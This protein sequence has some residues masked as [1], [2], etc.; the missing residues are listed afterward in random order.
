[1]DRRAL[2]YT[3][4]HY[5]KH[6]NQVLLMLCRAMYTCRNAISRSPAAPLPCLQY[7]STAEALQARAQ[8]PGAP[9]KKFH[10]TIKRQLI[11]RY[12]AGAT[13]AS[14]QQV[15]RIE[16]P[17]SCSALCQLNW[18]QRSLLCSMAIP[19]RRQA[20][21]LDH[22]LVPTCGPTMLCPTR[23]CT[24]NCTHPTPPHRFATG[25]DSL[26]DFACGR[27]GDIWKWIDA[28]IPRVMGVDLSP[29]EIEEARKR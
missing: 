10:N 27:G 15:V 6:S 16:A 25:V 28:G 5:D 12:V 1:M 11:N 3:R 23:S 24:Q 18:M 21:C 29:G 2:E 4:A 7:A 22:P 20:G 26:L 8:G 13:A 14:R 9:L 19:G 17:S